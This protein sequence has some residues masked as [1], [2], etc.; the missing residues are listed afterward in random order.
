ML[1]LEVQ[2]VGGFVIQPRLF[3]GE[4]LTDTRS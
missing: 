2:E 4:G 1:C 3:G